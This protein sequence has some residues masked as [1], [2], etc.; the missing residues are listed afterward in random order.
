MTITIRTIETIEDCYAIEQLEMAIWG[1]ASVEF[2]SHLMWVM[3]AEGGV[4][5]LALDDAEPVGFSFAFPALAAD[6]QLKLVSHQ[7]GGLPRYQSSGLGYQLKLYQRQE[8]LARGFN[9]I[10]WTFDPLQGRNARLNLGKLGATCHTYKPHFYG[11]MNDALN[12]GLPSDRFQVEWWIAS[13]HVQR[14]LAGAGVEPAGPDPACPVINP[15]AGWQR[16]FPVPGERFDLPTTPSCWVEIPADLA[17]LKAASLELALQWRLHT[18][19]VFEAAF[20]RGYTA[21]NLLAGEDRNYYLLQG[22]L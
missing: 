21:I 11:D 10:T 17:A 6:K 13:E 22:G 19:A 7:T 2:G 20:G 5:L 18:R 3:A 9:L 1:T 12:R 15:S 16:G 14:R 4:V 8:A